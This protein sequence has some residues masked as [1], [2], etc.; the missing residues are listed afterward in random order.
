MLI[1]LADVCAHLGATHPTN[2]SL[3]HRVYKDTECGA[4]AKVKE[5]TKYKT[6]REKWTVRYVKV[7]GVWQVLSAFRNNRPVELSVMPANVR[8]FFLVGSD[9]MQ[10]DV[11]A[12][13]APAASYEHTEAMESKY[14]TG[15]ELVFIVGSIVEGTDAEVQPVEVPLPASSKRIDMAIT[16]VEAGARELWMHTHGCEGCGEVG[17]PVDPDC[18]QCGGNGEVL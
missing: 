14:P 8:E 5:R 13:A 6:R 15:T 11:A 9:S 16:S 2:D 1:T 3:S 18:K 4:W 12:L 7:D 10:D 17:G